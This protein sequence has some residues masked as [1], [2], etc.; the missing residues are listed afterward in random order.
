MSNIPMELFEAEVTGTE[1]LSRD[2]VRIRLASE[3]LTRLAAPA[4]DGSGQV[5]DSYLKLFIPHP[6]LSGPVR[7]DLNDTWRKDW[8]AA[9]PKER[10]GWI[11]T[12]TLRDSRTWTS[13]AGSQGVEIDVDFVLHPAEGKSEDSDQPSEMGPGATWASRAKVGDS[14][15]F[16]GPSREGQLWSMWKPEQADTVIVCADETAVPAA[17]SVLRTLPQGAHAR[18]LLEVPEGNAELDRH[19]Q[20]LIEEARRHGDVELHWLERREGM[21]RGKLTL[22]ALREALGIEPHEDDADSPLGVK[23]A[24]DEIVWKTTE[25]PGSTYVYLAGEASV[26]R[27]ARRVC[28]N[29][30]NIE[31]S[32]ISFMGYWKAGHAES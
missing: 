1:R 20:P 2:F 23:V 25:D 13:P 14:L 29:E 24:A 8:F 28:V 5:L 10:G 17:M 9:D 18:F 19:A 27:A 30:A 6:E 26:V 15:S 4:G 22:Q 7:L 32:S 21:V 12:Y 31:K 16:I 3:Q 11:R